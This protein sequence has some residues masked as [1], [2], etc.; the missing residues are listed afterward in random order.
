[1][2]TR[3]ANSHSCIILQVDVPAP[4]L[5]HVPRDTIVSINARHAAAAVAEGSDDHICPDCDNILTDH[6]NSDQRYPSDLGNYGNHTH[7]AQRLNHSLDLTSQS[8]A[9]VNKHSLNEDRLED[10]VDEV[11]QTHVF[12]NIHVGDACHPGHDRSTAPPPYT[13]SCP[14]RSTRVV[15]TNLN[16]RNATTQTDSGDLALAS[17]LSPRRGPG[18][19]V[20]RTRPVNLHIMTR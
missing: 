4:R 7:R 3:A 14:R 20:T 17:V 1:M 9:V 5:G 16:A 15:Q 19:L 11:R 10:S 12:T 13:R 6:L 18:V 8:S 2:A